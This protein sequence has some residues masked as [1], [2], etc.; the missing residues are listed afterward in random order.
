MHVIA[1]VKVV[2]LTTQQARFIFN[3]RCHEKCLNEGKKE[4]TLTLLTSLNYLHIPICHPDHSQGTWR[5]GLGKDERE[6]TLLGPGTRR[7]KVQWH[8]GRKSASDQ[9]GLANQSFRRAASCSFWLERKELWSRWCSPVPAVL[10]RRGKKGGEEEEEDDK[11]NP[12]LPNAELLMHYFW[13]WC[14]LFFG[15]LVLPLPA[16]IMHK[17]SR[18]IRISQLFMGHFGKWVQNA[19]QSINE[20]AIK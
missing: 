3:H 9:Q 15:C 10:Q 5:T 12:S 1:G 4:E 8:A 11:R 7:E 19:S 14:L 13:T 17:Y 18:D 6:K 20:K 2:F 16:I